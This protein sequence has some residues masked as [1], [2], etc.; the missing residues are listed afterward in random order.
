MQ[1]KK[2]VSRL[3]VHY[4]INDNVDQSTTITAKN[5]ESIECNLN[6][7]QNNCQSCLSS[8]KNVIIKRSPLNIMF[9]VQFAQISLNQLI[10]QNLIVRNASIAPYVIMLLHSMSLNQFI[11]ETPIK[12]CIRCAFCHFVILLGEK[13]LNNHI[14]TQNKKSCYPWTWTLNCP[15]I[16]KTKCFVSGN[17]SQEN[18]KKVKHQLKIAD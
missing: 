4:Q 18:Y 10:C 8:H 16:R 15:V 5:D 14:Y 1:D 6:L 12:K 11:C 3:D 9:I 13:K 7:N 17:L 2:C